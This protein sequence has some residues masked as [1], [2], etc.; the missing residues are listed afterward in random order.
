MFEK[1]PGCRVEDGLG[2]GGGTRAEAGRPGVIQASVGVREE[3]SGRLDNVEV[4]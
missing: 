1:D 2:W 4:R 3:G